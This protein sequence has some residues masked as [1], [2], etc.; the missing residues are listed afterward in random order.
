MAEKNFADQSVKCGV[1]N[2]KLP[3]NVLH[4]EMRY[5]DAIKK[6]Y[7]DEEVID[8]SKYTDSSTFEIILQYH[9]HSPITINNNNIVQL[10]TACCSFGD[11]ILLSHCSDFIQTSICVKKLNTLIE[12]RENYVHF[13]QIITSINSYC[14]N[15][16]T[17]LLND[18]IQII[19]I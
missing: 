13:H 11:N 16:T 18:G 17:F 4:N 3:Y 1:K 15:Y 10:V 6:H 2:Y 8:I 9:G 19:L 14:K 5:F 12:N 7:I